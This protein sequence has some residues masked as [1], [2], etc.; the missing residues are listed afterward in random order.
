[1]SLSCLHTRV[2]DWVF[3]SIE[4]NIFFVAGRPVFWKSKRQETV[5]LSTV[6]AGYMG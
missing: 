1:M 4:C 2:L 5:A 3:L 6:E